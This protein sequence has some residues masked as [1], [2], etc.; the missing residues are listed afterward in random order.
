MGA[1]GPRSATCSVVSRLTRVRPRVDRSR[2]LPSPRRRPCRRPRLLRRRPLLLRQPPRP[3]RP[4][5][6]PRP[7]QRRSPRLP[8]HSRSGGEQASGFHTA[9]VDVLGLVRCSRPRWSASRTAADPTNPESVLPGSGSVRGCRIR[10][11]TVVRT[12]RVWICPVLSGPVDCGG[13][14]DRCLDLSGGC[15]VRLTAVVR[16]IGVW[17]RCCRIRPIT[18]VRTI[19][20]WTCPMSPSPAG[21]GRPPTRVIHNRGEIRSRRIP[22]STRL[23]IRGSP[24]RGTPAVACLSGFGWSRGL[25]SCFAPIFPLS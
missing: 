22:R 17:I 3:S 14:D 11:T 21:H 13:P 25:G 23:E 7:A 6:P 10:S 19:C 20:V 4:R 2:L 15:R 9:A 16:M 8:V 18:A 1:T 12:V 24:L 5:R